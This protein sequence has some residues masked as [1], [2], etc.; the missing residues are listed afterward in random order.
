MHV[1]LYTDAK[2]E[3]ADMDTLAHTCRR[4]II[5][6]QISLGRYTPEF[7]KQ[8]EIPALLQNFL[9]YSEHEWSKEFLQSFKALEEAESRL[10]VVLDELDPERHIPRSVAHN[11]ILQGVHRPGFPNP[12]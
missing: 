9:L 8:L 11:L 6:N 7:I 10:N 1:L 5:L 2:S 4:R 12:L 3:L